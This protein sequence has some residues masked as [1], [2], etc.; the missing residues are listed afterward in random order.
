MR[1]KKGHNYGTGKT[2]E[3]GSTVGRGQRVERA[4]GCYFSESHLLR[5]RRKII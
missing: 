3:T 1:I 5:S 2:V 4:V